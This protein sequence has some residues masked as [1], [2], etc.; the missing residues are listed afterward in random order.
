MWKTSVQRSDTPEAGKWHWPVTV[1]QQQDGPAASVV[2]RLACPQRINGMDALT[3][4]RRAGMLDAAKPLIAWLNDHC[5]P[6]CGA[7]VD[8]TTVVLTEGVGSACTTEFLR[9]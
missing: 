9:D 1:P 3:D 4:E 2:Q 7:H 8:Q 6:H 5:H